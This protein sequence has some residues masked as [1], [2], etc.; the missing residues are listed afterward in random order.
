MLKFEMLKV[1]FVLHAFHL[2]LQLQLVQ[3]DSLLV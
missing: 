2:R 3:M 1:L